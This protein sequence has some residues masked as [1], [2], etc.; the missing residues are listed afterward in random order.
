MGGG[1]INPQK[2]M[3]L[4]FLDHEEQ[5]KGHSDFLASL[6]HTHAS[7]HIGAAEDRHWPDSCC[8]LKGCITV[9]A[10]TG[11][12]ERPAPSEPRAGHQ[13]S[14]TPTRNHRQS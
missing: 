6:R 2:N 8:S 9:A 5:M 1:A 11:G 10:P 14:Y 3:L 13:T 4:T 7:L 12:F